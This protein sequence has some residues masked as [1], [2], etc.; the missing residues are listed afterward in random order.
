MTLRQLITGEQSEKS[1]KTLPALFERPDSVFEK[2]L[3]TLLH[4]SCCCKSWYVL[5]NDWNFALELDVLQSKSQIHKYSLACLR[6]INR[7][8][9]IQ[10]KYFLIG[11]HKSVFL[12]NNFLILRNHCKDYHGLSK[13]DFWHC[14]FLS[15]FCH[16]QRQ[17][18]FEIQNWSDQLK[19]E[20]LPDFQSWRL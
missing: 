8:V 5:V 19:L 17:S 12:R 20:S 9:R 10:I 14:M 1:C 3:S 7:I 11:V 16:Y 4:V 13:L 6:K 15:S 18:Q 2:A